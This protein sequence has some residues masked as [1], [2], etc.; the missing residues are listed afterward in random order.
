MDMSPPQALFSTVLNT[1]LT[2]GLSLLS[3]KDV[4]RLA[5]CCREAR[6]LCLD[7]IT[8]QRPYLLQRAVQDVHAQAISWLLQDHPQL[9]QSMADAL[10]S[11]ANVSLEG[12]C[13]LITRGLKPS[14]EQIAAKARQGVPG[15]YIWPR[16]YRH[17]Q[18]PSEVP[19]R[20]EAL[21]CGEAAVSSTAP[22]N[23]ASSLQEPHSRWSS[24]YFS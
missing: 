21:C 5:A 3:L 13:E 9:V 15:A 12:S 18:L 8:S 24:P 14:Y 7:L 19:L 23:H 6:D 20:A 16:A 17:L 22:T 11:T 1:V 2:N 4:L 10:L